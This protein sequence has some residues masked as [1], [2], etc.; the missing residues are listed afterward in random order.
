MHRHCLLFCILFFSL[1][2]CQ[3]SSRGVPRPARSVYYWR[4]VLKWSPA[5]RDFLQ[6]H[7]IRKLY[8]RYF[9]VVPA[10]KGFPRP[11]ATLQF[12]DTLPSDIEVIPVVF[13]MEH[14]LTA[15]IDTLAQR[16]ARRVMQMSETNGISDRVHEI[17]MDCDW[18]R[19]SEKQYFALLRH[20]RTILDPHHIGLS[21]TIRLHQLNMAAPPTDYGVLM[22]YN[23]GNPRDPTNPN[24]ILRWIDVKPYARYLQDYPLPLCAAYPD[25]RWQRLISH[26]RY[27]G[28]LYAEDLTDSTVYHS[29]NANT[30]VV[31][32]SRRV[33]PVV[34]GKPANDILLV[35]GDSVFIHESD[36]HEIAK[37]KN[38]LA[39]LRPELHRQIILYPLDA[40]NLRHHTAHYYET[41]Y[42]P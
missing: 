7:H 23:T 2:A 16:I 35:P 18:T 3:Y 10:E 29:L 21:A 42:Q 38:E 25:Y 1:V 14:A 9:D 30:Y 26:G 24:P 32:S 4:T 31:V 11:M 33:N 13:I 20:I 6:R 17:Q 34:G 5:E 22:L 36:P 28:L 40:K 37:V 12:N 15:P 39:R 27:K 41:L 19:H 8:L